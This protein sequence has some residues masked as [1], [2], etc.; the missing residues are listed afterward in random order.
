MEKNSI[1]AVWKDLE[2]RG[3]K[4][5]AWLIDPDKWDYPW[6]EAQAQKLQ[7]WHIPVYVFIGGSY[8]HRPGRL[9]ALIEALENFSF[10]TILFPGHPSQLAEGVDGIL[11]LSLV[12]GRNPA[13][14]ID[15]LVQAAP[16]LQ[17]LQQK[18]IEL[19]PTAY[20]LL[21]N[22]KQTT[23]HYITQTRGIPVDKP[24]LVA[25]TALAATFLGMQVVYLDSGSGAKFSDAI[26]FVLRTLK[27][28]IPENTPVIYGGGLRTKEQIQRCFE[29]GATLCVIGT[30]LE[31]FTIK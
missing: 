7:Q 13:Y 27:K 8:I 17:Q 6:L 16:Q 18:G 26:P 10:P 25:Y 23:V 24:E 31:D 20:L 11:V 3:E 15:Y 5:I 22:E 4:A 12:S 21:D 30:A 28:V 1:L 14:L 2:K 29:S 9:A 19:I